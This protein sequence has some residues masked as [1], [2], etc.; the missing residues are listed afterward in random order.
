MAINTSRLAAVVGA[1]CAACLVAFTSVQEGRSN[2]PY[3]DTGGVWT[4]CDGQTGVPMHYYTDSQC[5]AMLGNTL[6]H[7]AQQV[8]DM[9]PGFET[10]SDGVKA[11]TVDFAYNV[12]LG[13]YQRS[14]LRTK[15]I[16]RQLP[17]AC[18]VFLRYKLAG[19]KDCSDRDNGCY[20]VWQ[21][22]QA[23]RSMCLGEVKQ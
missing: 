6:A 14:S 13:N 23:E 2:E 18:D 22:R 8:Q 19:G 5:D 4:V 9:T 16:A 10:L 12:G 15:L 17:A 7:I 21:R 11:A 20:G 3:R 1:A